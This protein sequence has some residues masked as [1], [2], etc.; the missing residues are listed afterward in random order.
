MKLA[1]GVLYAS[2][3]P[4]ICFAGPRHFTFV[5]EAPT[6]PPG[7]VEI[8]NWATTRFDDGFTDAQ[9]R[10]EIEIGVSEHF[11]ASDNS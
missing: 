4:S 2:L 10:H 5:Y 7:S 1:L 11:Q 8:E 6:S 9:F 3:L